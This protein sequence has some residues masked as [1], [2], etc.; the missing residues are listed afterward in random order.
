MYYLKVIITDRAGKGT[1]SETIQCMT[2]VEGLSEIMLASNI[3][4]YIDYEPV[5]GSFTSEAQYNGSG[6]QTF[7]TDNSLNWRIL[8]VEDKLLTLISDYTVNIN[9]TLRGYNGY[10]NGVLLL[11]N[12]CK[13]MYSNSSLGAT[14]RSL[15][16]DDVESVSSY[17]KTSDSG[18]YGYLR[19]A[20][21]N[22]PNI[23]A[24]EKN[25]GINGVYGTR[26]EQS[27]QISYI[28]GASATSNLMGII[29]EYMYRLTSSYF[30]SVYL[31]LIAY[32]PGTTSYFNQTY[33]LASRCVGDA[34]SRGQLD[35]GMYYIGD[36]MGNLGYLRGITT[37]YWRRW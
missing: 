12:A 17:D 30:D 35:Y 24:D 34:Y 28:T 16:V 11:N 33:W 3:G 10:N 23:F 21:G 20:S 32:N 18:G 36:V 27:E 1:N 22:Y 7:S 5:S 26:Y 6:N 37:M 15:N 29:T 2:E 19:Q 31:E 8:F 13:A 9:F 4:K 25:G 14:G